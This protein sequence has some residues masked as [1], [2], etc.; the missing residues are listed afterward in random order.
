MAC[1]EGEDADQ[2]VQRPWLFPDAAAASP[3]FTVS[4]ISRLKQRDLPQLAGARR[5]QGPVCD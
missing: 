4:P 5:R 3:A 2:G 1:T